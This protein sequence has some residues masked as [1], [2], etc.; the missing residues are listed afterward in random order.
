MFV[1][2]FLYNLYLLQL[3]FRENFLGTMSGMMT[4]G[5]V[6]GSILA[7][8]AMQRYGLRRTLLAGFVLTA[9]IAALRAYITLPPA[10]LGLAGGGWNIV[11]GMAG[12]S[13]ARRRTIDDT[14]KPPAG[15]QSGVLVGNRNRYRGRARGWTHARM[16]S[17]VAHGI[18]D[19]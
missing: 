19:G 11:S 12:C 2:F 10:L 13:F 5:S 14:E 3:G 4:A 18:V 15:F 17:K 16:A 8:A 1:F 6:V 7:V 9:C